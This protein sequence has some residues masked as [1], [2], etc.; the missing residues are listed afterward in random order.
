[1]SSFEDARRHRLDRLAS[2]LAVLEALPVGALVVDLAGKIVAA[3]SEAE[4][5]FG[6]APGELE[7]ASVELLMAEKHRAQHARERDRFVGSQRSRQMA[8]GRDLEGLRKDGSVVPLQ[9]GLSQ[10]EV[11]EGAFVLA[12]V[13]E[14]AAR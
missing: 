12:I 14:L 10:I 11:D 2:L 5:L 7:G 6:Y 13:L 8:A 4:K 1:M 9:I 3:S